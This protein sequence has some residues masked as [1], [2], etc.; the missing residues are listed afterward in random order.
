MELVP[1]VRVVQGVG[2]DMDWAERVLTEAIETAATTGDR[3]LAAHALVQRGFLRLF[4]GPDV[5]VE[6]LLDTAERA[7]AAFETLHDELGLARGWR[8]RAQAYYLARCAALSADASERALAHAQRAGDRFEEREIVE[9]LVI[10]L[11]WGPVAT[12]EGASRCGRLL[13]ECAGDPG[14]ES[15]VLGALALFAAM[16]GRLDESREL[17]AEA[18]RTLG[19]LGEGVWIVSFHL[20]EACVWQGDAAGAEAELR[21]L[22]EMLKR[23][24]EKS[25]FSAMA[26]LLAD[27]VYR[28]GRLE[29]AE[30]LTVECEL[31]ARA[32]DVH[33]Q[34]RWRA[35]RAKVLAGRE[36]QAAE[37][38]AR[39][40]VALAHEGDFVTARA[41]ALMDL[42]EVLHVCGRRDEATAAAQEA[43]RDYELK[44]NVL[45]ADQARARLET[46]GA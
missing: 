1:N 46:L 33:D 26:Q 31:A 35:V 39:Q 16:S 13:A 7:I 28:Q 21:P 10:A 23:I 8:L 5:T 6:E 45:A 38:L 20:A 22:Y 2:A 4:T 14:S 37:M 32:N 34:I 15:L 42:A 24:G 12:A 43:I 9:W 29:E 17:A 30:Q 3:G 40:A 25:H 19:E 27:A 36:P 11:L 44:G 41:G 18:R